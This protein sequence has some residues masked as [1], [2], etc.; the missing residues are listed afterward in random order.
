M[1]WLASVGTGLVAVSRRLLPYG[2]LLT[3]CA[4][5]ALGVLGAGTVV[6]GFTLL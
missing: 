2:E 6:Y 4:A 3:R 5:A 1:L